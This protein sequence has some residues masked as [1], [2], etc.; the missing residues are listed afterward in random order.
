MESPRRIC[1]GMGSERVNNIG[2]ILIREYCK[3]LYKER[4][5][6]AYEKILNRARSSVVLII[7]QKNL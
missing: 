5:E 2:F 3:D 1:V 6:K 4:E 7:K